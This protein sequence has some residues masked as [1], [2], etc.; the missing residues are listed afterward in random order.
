[1][2]APQRMILPPQPL[3][4]LSAEYHNPKF[5]E[6]I[7]KII[8]RGFQ[9][10][11]PVRGDGNCFYRSFA[12]VMAELSLLR[13]KQAYDMF[14]EVLK[15]NEKAFDAELKPKLQDLINEFGKA[16]KQ[17]VIVTTSTSDMGN[18]QN[19][20]LMIATTTTS[21][22]SISSVSVPSEASNS[23]S[24]TS[25]VSL[26]A[27]EAQTAQT[28]TQ[29]TAQTIQQTEAQTGRQIIPKSEARTEQQT[30]AQTTT[31]IPAQK[32]TTP[33]PVSEQ[34]PNSPSPPVQR[35]LQQDAMLS[36][37]HL[38]RIVNTCQLCDTMGHI[39]KECPLWKTREHAIGP[40]TT[41]TSTHQQTTTTQTQN[42]KPAGTS[43]QTNTSEAQTVGSDI[44]TQTPTENPTTPGPE[45]PA[46]FDW[47]IDESKSDTLVKALRQ[48]IA[49]NLEQNVNYQVF[50]PENQSLERRAKL[51][52]TMGEEA[53]HLEISILTNVLSV[54]I[55][56]FQLDRS[57]TLMEYTIPDDGN[58]EPLYY[59]LYRPGDRKSVV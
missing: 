33:S 4:K 36:L 44:R 40:S 59:F 49:F 58:S 50:I 14:C 54:K 52:R 42:E 17:T 10:Y 16:H 45:R 18:Q 56:L 47:Y 30:G 34:N 32:E 38:Y 20:T 1:M 35:S 12:L 27:A 48:L 11:Q 9:S 41:P 5:H 29:T 53:E 15:R 51:I 46:I 13:D 19:D 24:N 28:E 21:S 23:V 26:P 39:A 43:T 37:M 3:E 57:D 2:D 7:A 31:Q 25:S 8:S 6:H 22:T 55:K